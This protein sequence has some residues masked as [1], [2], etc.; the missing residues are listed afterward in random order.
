MATPSR[1]A[2]SSCLA[3]NGTFRQVNDTIRDLAG[4]TASDEGWEFICEC[5]DLSCVQL[6]LLTLGEFDA[7]R[8]A[9]PPLPVLAPRHDDGS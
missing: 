4:R 8:T 5:D 3:S 1:D 6:V 7:H 9:A 2:K